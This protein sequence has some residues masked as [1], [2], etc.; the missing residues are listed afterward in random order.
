MTKS[1]VGRLGALARIQKHGNPGTPL[2]RSLGGARSIQTH[3]RLKT[4]FKTGKEFTT[5]KDSEDLAEFMG[6]WVGDGHLAKYQASMST[7]SKTD[8][9]H[10]RY[11]KDLAFRLFGQN[12][13]IRKKKDAKAVELVIS[14]IGLV[15]WLKTKG[16]P[17]GNKMSG[18]C[19]PD[20]IKADGRF[21]RKFIRGL[22]DTDGCIFIDTHGIRGKQYRNRGWTITSYSAKLRNEL[23]DLLRNLGFNPTL[24]DSQVS[25]YMR[26]RVDIERYF[27][28]IGTSNKKHLDRYNRVT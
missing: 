9:Q 4:N 28:E 27:R 8:M 16:M 11:V 18:L 26:K 6:I 21:S 1:Q 25:V 15:E 22:F 19:I 5:P 3:K 23:V 14:S 12:G 13:H 7:S 20:W 2:G 17:E 10:A 24:R